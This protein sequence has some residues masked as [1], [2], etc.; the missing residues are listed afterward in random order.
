[1]K[2]N[3]NKKLDKWLNTDIELPKYKREFCCD[4]CGL[5][6]FAET[7]TANETICPEC[8]NSNRNGFIYACDSMAYAY[9]YVSIVNSLKEKGKA[10][11]FH[12]EHTN[13]Q[14]EQMNNIYR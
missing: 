6:W 2:E 7:T 11:H 12:K 9:A 5:I 8:G 14:K 10:I 3:A 1:M 13:H 4:E